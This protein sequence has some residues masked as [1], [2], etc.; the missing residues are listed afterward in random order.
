MEII[1]HSKQYEDE[2]INLIVGIQAGEF[3]VPITAADQPDLRTV[4]TF[5]QQGN[6]NFWLA[7]EENKVV[8]TIALIDIGHNEV[9]LRKMFV[10]PEHRGRDKGVAQK[11]I[12][13]VFDW[14]RQQQVQR[15][16]LGTIEPFKAAHRFYERNGFDRIKKEQLP[17]YFP[18]M[19]LDTI[20]YTYSFHKQQP[21]RIILIGFMGSGKT[22]WG[23]QVAHRLN[24]PFFDLDEEVVKAEDG[25]TVTEIFADSGE[26]YFRE[27]E[28]E[29]MEKLVET[30][31][32]MVLSCG[33]GTPCFY[34]NIEYMKKV[35]IVVWLNTSVDVLL[36]R[37]L[38]EKAK[39]P[40]IKDIGDEELRAYIL[41]KLNERRMYYEQADVV[42][43]KEDA[44]SMNDFIQ[45]VLHA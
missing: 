27:K 13:V 43:D 7:L 22:H 33:G 40:L 20:F 35:G 38:K 25:K 18:A 19:P 24:L 17:A 21:M 5:Y 3:G 41:R 28:K 4:N 16:L 6:G 34:N 11:L 12:E 10:H 30:N 2:T 37:L 39:R 23:K 14:C 36:Q 1:T 15:I 29:T 31:E 45:T 8:G 44:I 9:A 32:S 42:M 26:E